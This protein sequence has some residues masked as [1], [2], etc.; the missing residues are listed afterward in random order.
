MTNYAY[1][2]TSKRATGEEKRLNATLKALASPVRRRLVAIVF[3][4]PQSTQTASELAERLETADRTLQVGSLESLLVDLHHRHLPMLSDAGLI[5]YDSE[6][7][8]ATAAI[9]TSTLEEGTLDAFEVEF[10]NG[11][12]FPDRS[13]EET[14][15][16]FKALA[17]PRRRCILETLSDRSHAVTVESIAIELTSQSDAGTD[18]SIAPG[19]WR[20]VVGAITHADLPLLEDAGLIE[21]DPDANR[22]RSRLGSDRDSETAAIVELSASC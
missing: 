2:Q 14:D 9:E 19:D 6:T 20:H 15:A 3:D 16:L 13:A 18:R 7:K 22:V 5:A 12:E 21:Y 17:D 11:F 10:T 1:G 4:A 8:R